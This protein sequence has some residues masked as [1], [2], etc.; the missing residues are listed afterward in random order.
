MLTQEVSVVSSV[1]SYT[2]VCKWKQKSN[3]DESQFPPHK[4]IK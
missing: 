2:Y 4:L 1:T 3:K